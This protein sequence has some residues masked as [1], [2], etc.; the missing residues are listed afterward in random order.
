M[1]VSCESAPH[2]ELD[3]HIDKYHTQRRAPINQPNFSNT[4]FTSE[5][6]TPSKTPY[7]STSSGTSLL[8]DMQRPIQRMSRVLEPI[9]LK[10]PTEDYL[11]GVENEG[12]V[13]VDPKNHKKRY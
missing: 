13:T 3:K 4:N 6:E 1:G 8:N 9:A 2:T 5:D 11:A 7:D 12:W 10:R